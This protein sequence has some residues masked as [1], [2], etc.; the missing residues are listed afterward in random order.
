LP[1]KLAVRTVKELA[2]PSPIV[3]VSA[4]KGRNIDRLRARISTL[5]VPGA[6]KE[7][8]IILHARQRDSLQAIY[9]AL[10]R[11]RALL[12]KKQ[13]EE[14]YAEEIRTAIRLVGEL[15]GE[16]SAEEVLEDIF[17]RFCVGK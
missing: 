15:T 12:A 3:E 7:E 4:L 1:R 10:R 14:V 16:V 8:E 13:S 5:F 11:A 9:A 17:G 2:G 6:G